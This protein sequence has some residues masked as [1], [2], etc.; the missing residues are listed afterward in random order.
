MCHRRIHLPPHFLLLRLD[1]LQPLTLLTRHAV[2]LLIDQLDQFAYVAFRQNVRPNLLDNQALEATGIE[3]GRVT[4]L[5]AAVEDRL[6]DVVAVLPALRLCRRQG[7]ATE[8]AADEAAQQISTGSMARM[9]PFRGPRLQGLSDP[10]ANSARDTMAGK[11]LLNAYRRR[12]ALVRQIP[13]PS[14][15]VYDSLTSILWI[16]VFNHFLPRGLG[17]PSAFSVFGN[18]QHALPCERHVE[19][20]ARRRRRP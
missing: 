9:H 4:T 19:D 5:A 15:P 16:V 6:T 17:M 7:L 1:R 12:S 18:L 2:H 11:R 10:L 8:F 3:P 20:P 14:V 13:R